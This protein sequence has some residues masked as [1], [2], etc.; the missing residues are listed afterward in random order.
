MA[1]ELKDTAA[2]KNRQAFVD[3]CG[4]L[5]DAL[6]IEFFPVA[7]LI[8]QEAAPRRGQSNNSPAALEKLDD[9]KF[10]QIL[11]LCCKKVPVEFLQGVLLQALAACGGMAHGDGTESEGDG[12]SSLAR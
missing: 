4:A 12:G 6:A 3:C 2:N 1:K 5:K 7:S 11:R 10:H 8:L 9:D